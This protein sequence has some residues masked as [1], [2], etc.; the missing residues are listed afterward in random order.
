M[1]VDHTGCQQPVSSTKRPTRVTPVTPSRGCQIG[2]AAHTGCHQLVRRLQQNQ[3]LQKRLAKE[4]KAARN[5][6]WPSPYHA[7]AAPPLLGVEAANV[8]VR[9]GLPQRSGAS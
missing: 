6:W 5:V 7:H 4:P 3:K 9:E 8:V 2:H 1:A